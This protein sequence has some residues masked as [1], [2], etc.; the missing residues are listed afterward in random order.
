VLGLLIGLPAWWAHSFFE[1]WLE[2]ILAASA[3]PR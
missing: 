1:A 2:R 3:A